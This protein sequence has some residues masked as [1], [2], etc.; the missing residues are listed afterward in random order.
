MIAI[1]AV[2]DNGKRLAAPFPSAAI[3]PVRTIFLAAAV[4]ALGHQPCVDVTAG[5]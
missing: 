5:V 1:V 2:G 4:I 3:D